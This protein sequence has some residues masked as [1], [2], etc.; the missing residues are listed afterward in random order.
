MIVI[1]QKK[2]LRYL[3]FVNL[4]LF[5]PL[6]FSDPFS[7]KM[8]EEV[9]SVICKSP[10]YIAA[11]DG[12]KLGY[13]N[14]IPEHPHAIMIFYHGSGLWSNQLYQ[15]MAQELE[16]KYNIGTYLFDIRGH[17]NSEGNRGDAPSKTQ[18]WQ[19]ISTAI[20]YVQQKHKGCPV[21]LGGHS[22]GAGLVLN[23]SSWHKHPALQGYV[24]LAPFLGT[25]SGVTYEHSDPDKN[26]IK[27]V[28]LFPLIV[29]I[30]SFGFFFSHT[31]VIFF[32]YSEQEK[33]KDAHLLESYTCAMT[34]AT[35]PNDPQSIFS[36]LNKPYL[37]LIGQND[38]QFIP[39]KVMAFKSFA[40]QV[41]DRSVAHIMPQ[42]THLSVLINAPSII[43]QTLKKW[44][45]KKD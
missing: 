10:Q 24:L 18:V 7:F 36:Q 42:E 29:N 44:F 37:M 1:K 33:Q 8:P 19:D 13:Y 45:V 28:R 6:L 17:G 43:A 2:Y 34:N 22:S 25:R 3:L 12:V 31:H 9:S 40:P 41:R 16:Q 27:S 4:F 5:Q 38:E 39:E 15:Y 26:F 11:S 20:N 23:Y 21:V 32:N 35:T 14:F 30:L